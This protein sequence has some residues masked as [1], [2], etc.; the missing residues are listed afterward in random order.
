M[1]GIIKIIREVLMSRLVCAL[2]FVASLSITRQTNAEP[3]VD[4]YKGKIIQLIVGSAPGGGFYLYARL[5]SRYMSSFLPG[6]PNIIVQN[7]PGAGGLVAANYIY[8]LAPK[9]GTTFGTF[10][11]GLIT[12]AIL[13]TNP[14]VRFDPRKFV[15]LGSTSSFANDAYV[16][17]ARKDAGIQTVEES[18]RPGSPKLI[19]GAL[20][21]GGKEMQGAVLARDVLHLNIQIIPGYLDAPTVANAME[22]GEVNAHMT[23]LFPLEASKPGWLQPDGPMRALIQFARTTRLPQ[24]ADVPTAR[25]LAQNP[26]SLALVKL[27]EMSFRLARP[28]VAAPGTPPDRAKALQ[29]AFMKAVNDPGFVADA[30]KVKLDVSPADGDTILKLINEVADF[31]PDVMEKMQAIENGQ[32]VK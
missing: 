17:I 6:N 24:L 14:N 1:I 22:R 18:Q 4:F 31:S 13:G 5:L 9:D 10:D 2:L 21:D 26:T 30:T 20:A 28:F 7:M 12:L 19:I 23:E 3:L 32:A 27:Y 8:G 11:S 15:W 29:D 16:L 25:E